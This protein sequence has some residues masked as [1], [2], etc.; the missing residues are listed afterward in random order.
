MTNFK[1]SSDTMWYDIEKMHGSNGGVYILKCEG[2]DE[3][4]LPV[5]RL[6]ATYFNGILYIGS[7]D[8]NLYALELIEAAAKEMG[9]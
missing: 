8:G 3:C 5:N 4:A 9:P 2:S 7:F 6:L 1:I